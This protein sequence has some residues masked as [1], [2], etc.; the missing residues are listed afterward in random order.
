MSGRD[1]MVGL[2]AWVSEIWV[3]S[4]EVLGAAVDGALVISDMEAMDD[5][6]CDKGKMATPEDDILLPEELLVE[7]SVVS[8]GRESIPV[9]LLPLADLLCCS[10]FDEDTKD[11]VLS[12]SDDSASGK[13]VSRS[14][15]CVKVDVVVVFADAEIRCDETSLVRV[16]DRSIV[17]DSRAEVKLWVVSGP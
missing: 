5:V 12:I 16:E 8:W 7:D 14:V 4:E 2:A 15:G 9:L 17:E 13:D 3:G 11:D 6:V 10:L 1:V